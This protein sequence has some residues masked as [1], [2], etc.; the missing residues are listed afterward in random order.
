MK[1]NRF[2]FLALI[3]LFFTPPLSAWQIIP[4]QQEDSLFIQ[5]SQV[6]QV[7]KKHKHI[8]QQDAKV[9]ESLAQ[10]ALGSEITK[11]IPIA[12]DEEDKERLAGIFKPFESK[13]TLSWG[14]HPV[15]LP[16]QFGIVTAPGISKEQGAISISENQKVSFGNMLG[17]GDSASD[18]QFIEM[19]K[20]GAAMGNAKQGLKDLVLSKGKDYS[21]IGSSVDENGIIEILDHFIKS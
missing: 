7:T 15:A 3:S 18:W 11:L 21:Y 16:L 10:E 2:F 19:C 14:V 20:Y 9:T 6:S 17:V 8:L 12:K 1:F 13:L 5:E 4:Y